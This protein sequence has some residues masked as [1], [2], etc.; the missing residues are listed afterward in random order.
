MMETQLFQTPFFLWSVALVIGAPLLTILLSEVSNRLDQQSDPLAGPLRQVRN[1]VVPLWA[2]WL[3]IH[4][5]AEL[6]NDIW[7]TQVVITLALL[8]TINAALAFF[9]VIFFARAAQH[10]WQAKAPKLLID[11]FRSVFVLV[12][13]AIL[14]STVWGAD[15]GG[16]LAALGIGSII[17]G[18]AL[19]DS[20]GGLIKG[21]LL[22]FERPFTNG[23]L[24]RVGDTVG[25][26]V[27]INWRAVHLETLFHQLMVI[28]NANL[29]GETIVNL[30]RPTQRYMDRIMI[31]FSYD[32]PPAQVKEILLDLALA[33]P[34]VLREPPVRVVTLAY[35]D[36][37]ITYGVIF[38]AVDFA[39]WQSARDE[40]STRLWYVA[41]RHSLSIPFPM[42]TVEHRMLTPPRPGEASAAVVKGVEQLAELFPL[43][44]ELLATLRKSSCHLLYGK[45]EVVVR[46]GEKLDHLYF[47]LAGRASLAIGSRTG[48][49]H[50]VT[51]LG[52]EEF[53]GVAALVSYEPSDTTVTVIEDLAVLAIDVG[54]MQEV[55]DRTPRYAQA[56]S[57]VIDVRRKAIN[58]LRATLTTVMGLLLLITVS[59]CTPTIPT[60][61]STAVPSTTATPVAD[62]TETLQGSEPLTP[63][64]PTYTSYLAAARSGAFTSTVVSI[65]GP[66]EGEDAEH[67]NATLADFEAE[68][69]IDIQYSGT[70]QFERTVT[71][72]VEGGDLPDIIDFPQPGLLRRFAAQGDVIDVSSFLPLAQLQRQ[73]R[74]GWIEMSQMMGPAGEPIIAGVWQR[75]AV[76][77]LVWYSPNA[78]Q[79]AGYAVPTTWDE[80]QALMAR[81]VA[82]GHTPWCI[83]IASAASTGWPATD[84]IEDLLLRTAS[85][86]TYDQWTRGI[87]PFTASPVQ[88]AV[89]RMA[90][91]W[92][93]P[94]YVVGGRT[95]ITSTT[96][97]DAPLGLFTDPPQCW[98]HKQ[99]SFITNYFPAEAEP[100]VD[101]APF[102][103]PPIDPAYGRPMLVSGDLMAMFNDRPEVRAVMEYFTYA[104]HL[105]GWLAS[106][107][108]L[109]PQQDVDLDWYGRPLERTLAILA[110][111]STRLRFDGSDLMPA[112]VGSGAFWE[113]ITLYVSGEIDLA[114]AL[115]TID[116]AWPE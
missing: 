53:F 16:L 90:E 61:L 20:V 112:A 3:L 105:K 70:R 56:L 1:F 33:T 27:E 64:A 108:V 28:P 80:L 13:I 103:F 52:P 50:E 63:T 74:P 48:Q 37:A 95:A 57:E 98:L 66:F 40:F 21:I 88:Q 26:V 11:L 4:F 67:F 62:A 12:G 39:T 58:A 8:A 94:A 15:L 91:I 60:P 34:G 68:T 100:L 86:E 5:V 116:A 77:S 35:A 32:D 55:L 97:S 92:F 99:A 42:R 31:G 73:Y 9:N 109:A 24:L 36:S 82:D 44:E 96:F 54:V 78:W 38:S 47:I 76:K 29:A 17:I 7:W 19:Q 6:D 72:R 114:T 18:L 107:G 85:I 113:Q 111:E 93:D 84:W 81:M 49:L 10:T 79:A 89:E 41:K 104:E 46:Q 25:R 87:L 65:L 71:I 43:E 102:Y 14:L 75:F 45:N 83:G 59:A 115:A 30:S 2:L 106:G 51:Q 101:Y 23:D 69:G 110:A 22:I